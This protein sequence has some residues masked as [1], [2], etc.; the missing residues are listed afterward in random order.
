MSKFRYLQEPAGYQ[1]PDH[2]T[3]PCH[4]AMAPLHTDIGGVCA[5]HVCVRAM[6]IFSV[7]NAIQL[8]PKGTL[9]EASNACFLASRELPKNLAYLAWVMCTSAANHC[10]AVTSALVWLHD[11]I[12]SQGNSR[13]ACTSTLH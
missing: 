1:V 6:L 5:C 4:Q 8:V 12:K 11:N 7:S 13:R 2:Q 9:P 10:C 3:C